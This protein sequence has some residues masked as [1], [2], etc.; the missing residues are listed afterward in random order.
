MICE[1]IDVHCRIDPDANFDQRLGRGGNVDEK[2]SLMP[3]GIFRIGGGASSKQGSVLVGGEDP[4]LTIPQ[5]M[6]LRRWREHLFE[7]A[8]IVIKHH[9]E[10]SL[11]GCNQRAE[12]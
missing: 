3:G 8:Y 6:Q 11:Y 5:T 7:A 2:N 4:Q 9:L 10:V 1:I 12:T